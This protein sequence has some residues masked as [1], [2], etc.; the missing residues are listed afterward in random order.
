MNPLCLTENL[1]SR[2]NSW[3]PLFLTQNSICT[4]FVS[5]PNR[6]YFK[7]EYEK[8]LLKLT[9]VTLLLPLYGH[10]DSLKKLDPVVAIAELVLAVW[11]MVYAPILTKKETKKQI[12][13]TNFVLRSGSKKVCSRANRTGVFQLDY[14]LKP[15]CSNKWSGTFFWQEH[16]KEIRAAE[17]WWPRLPANRIIAIN[18][19]TRFVRL[20]TDK[21]GPQAE[22]CRWSGSQMHCWLVNP[23]H[24]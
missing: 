24:S 20:T 17:R 19:F 9:V 7:Q 13:D 5:G 14:Y 3:N 23:E 21:S 4:E 11:T 18:K 12:W 2:P 15:L 8:A 10:L 16:A 6:G 22:V 1:R